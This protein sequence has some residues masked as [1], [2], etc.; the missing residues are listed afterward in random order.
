M[1]RV[2]ALVSAL[3]FMCSVAVI[4]FGIPMTVHASGAFSRGNGSE[5]NPYR[6]STCGQLQ[7]I[8][9]DLDA[10][11]ELIAN[12][13]CSA[14]NFV[15][16][17]DSDTPFSG[18]LEGNNKIIKNLN[19]DDFGLFGEVNNGIIHNIKLVDATVNGSTNVGIL[20]GTVL[21]A[22]TNISN[23]HAVGA[24]V[25]GSS[26]YIGG[27]VGTIASNYPVLEKSSFEGTV[28]SPGVMGGFIGSA[29]NGAYIY[30]NYVK[31]TL[32][33]GP[34]D[35]PTVGGFVGLA[36]SNQMGNNYA[37]TT[38][39]AAN[40]GFNS[41]VGGF[42]G[43][44]SGW[45][46]SSFA[47]M[48]YN[49]GADQIGD[50]LGYAAGLTVNANYYAAKGH[51]WASNTNSG[52]GVFAV[53]TSTTPN[54]F[55]DS[56][57]APFTYWDFENT[58][59]Q[60]DGD[61]PRLRNEA[62]FNEG[63]SDINGDSIIDTYQANVMGVSDT[64][65]NM[66]V[67]ELD[68]ASDCT[69]DPTGSSVNSAAIKADPVY[70]LQIP[71]M[72]AFTVYCPTNGAQVSVTLV[73]PELYDTSKSVLRFY[74]DVTDEYHTVSGVV[75]GTRTINGNEVTTATYTLV[76][77]GENDTDATQNGVIH[78]PVG[79]AINTSQSSEGSNSTTAPGAGNLAQTGQPTTFLTIIASILLVV[80]SA[81][82]V[83]VIKKNRT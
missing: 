49:S 62:L 64:N 12:I 72:T 40:G 45:I 34:D 31:A 21:G 9:N 63:S 50:F 51:W 46:Q 16:I 79:I 75:F 80:S 4:N 5:E 22:D 53:D 10:F 26:N 68:S 29:S 73:Y 13:D 52:G 66:T 39:D 38:I 54:Y 25:S 82:W 56:S 60:V 19:I 83:A 35:S 11:Y 30:N 28:S 70:P 44:G 8:A 6:I 3:V 47:D 36:G 48:T 74:N 59:Q 67:V 15:H 76:D 7:A 71:T 24:S 37:V 77:G 81:G 23:I 17:G 58:W 33:V 65:D 32:T 20:A 1:K 61:Y 14:T 42:G 43:L 57:N 55:K 78:D 69:L 27:M 2:N 18:N 41:T